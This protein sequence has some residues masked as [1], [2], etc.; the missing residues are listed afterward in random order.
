MLLH[1]KGGR[2]AGGESE[3]IQFLLGHVSVQTELRRGQETISVQPGPLRSARSGNR[4][5]SW[6][7][8]P[9]GRKSSAT[10]TDS[11]SYGLPHPL[12]D[13]RRGVVERERD[14]PLE[15]LGPRDEHSD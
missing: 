3:Q 2:A 6:G 9:N 8:H 12:R 10:S 11:V 13:R 7:H 14:R 15:A 4:T 5:R 1:R